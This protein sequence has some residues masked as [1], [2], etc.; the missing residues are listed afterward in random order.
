M[1]RLI[2]ASKFFIHG[3][4]GFDML[5]DMMVNKLNILKTF[6]NVK[7]N[8]NQLVTVG[9]NRK[10]NSVMYCFNKDKI[11]KHCLTFEE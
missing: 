4:D 6:T 8:C 7:S 9:P 11:N 5:A 2:Y 1:Y 10:N 3:K